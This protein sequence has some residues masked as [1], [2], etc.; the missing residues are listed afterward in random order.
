MGRC[1]PSSFQSDH[2]E[3]QLPSSL[4]RLEFSTSNSFPTVGMAGG[5]QPTTGVQD[6][7]SRNPWPQGGRGEFQASWFPSPLT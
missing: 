1:I 4:P 3:H 6:Q 5:A 2:L 7:V